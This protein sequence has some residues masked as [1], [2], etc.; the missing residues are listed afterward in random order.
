MEKTHDYVHPTPHGGRCR[1]RIYQDGDDLPVVVC[2]EP[3]DNEGTSI[4]NSAEQ[5]GAGVLK[6]HPDVFAIG[7]TS[8]AGTESGKP[9][10]WIE[11]YEDGARGTPQDRATFDLVEFAHYEPRDVRRPE[12]WVKEIGE[13]SWKA[14][15]RASVEA[16]IGGPL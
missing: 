16:L 7:L 3:K 5:I 6:K 13:P 8:R 1:V 11:H 4:T 15:D 12:G 10:V 2:T 9:F 14:L